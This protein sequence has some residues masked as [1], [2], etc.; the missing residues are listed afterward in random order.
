[1]AIRFSSIYQKQFLLLFGFISVI[2]L[3]SCSEATLGSKSLTES[4]PATIIEG[5]SQPVALSSDIPVS[6]NTDADSV[7]DG[8]QF[9]TSVRLRNLTLNI[10]ESSEQQ[11]DEDGAMDDFDFL[12]GMEI[13]MTA[14]ISGQDRQVLV[15]SLPEGDSQIGSG[16]RSLAF[17][18]ENVDVLD[19]L[20]APSGFDLRVRGE[21]TTPPDS[22]IFG[23]EL[24]FRVGLGLRF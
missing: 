13:Y 22:V 24:R 2:F 1:M 6:L 8:T 19:F 23:G 16:T 17:T 18:V 10:L 21:G 20:E 3:A 5:S 7:A 15:A 4:L 9:V 12:S 11:A 14:R